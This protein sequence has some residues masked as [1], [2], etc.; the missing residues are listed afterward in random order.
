M[1]DIR[2]HHHR[3]VPINKLIRIPGTPL[4]NATSECALD[5]FDFVRTI[6]VARVLMP[7]SYIR[8]SAG[9]EQMSDELQVCKG[10]IPILKEGAMS[11]MW[12]FLIF[13]IDNSYFRFINKIS[14]KMFRSLHHS[15][16]FAFWPVPTHCFT[17]KSC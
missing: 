11:E 5:P 16:L 3:S 14:R 7:K 1:G 17:G 13:V 6:A 10:G 4:A 2:R 9:R 15:R 12:N 8:L